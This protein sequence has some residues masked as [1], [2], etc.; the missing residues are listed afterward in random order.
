MDASVPE[1]SL[2][3]P[4]FNEEANVGPLAEQVRKA[5]DA[6]GLAYEVVCVDDGSRDG[7]CDQLHAVRRVDPRFQVMKLRRNFG[8]TQAMMAG[9]EHARGRTIV[10]MD[11]D[12][13]NDPTDIPRLLQKLDEGYDVVCGWRKN[14]KDTYLSRKLP[15]RI[16]NSLIGWITGVRVHDYGCSL[17]AYRAS[18]VKGMHMYSDMHRFIPAIATL[19][20]SKVTEIVVTHHPRTAGSSKYGI[21]RTVNVLLDLVV[22]KMIVG[23]ASRPAHWFALLSLPFFLMAG[24]SFLIAFADQ[25]R[26]LQRAGIGRPEGMGLTFATIGILFFFV[27][28]HLTALGLVS[29][30]ILKSGDYRPG[31]SARGRVAAQ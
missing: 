16:A 17:K 14:R 22:V 15:S 2:V 12:L 10:S 31:E 5:L 7:T 25:I 4:F 9:F 28:V 23:F 3:I 21:S 11:G 29:E 6:T 20:G 26:L 24:L 19:S 27:S 30:L 1:L 18:V 8:Q 13:Q